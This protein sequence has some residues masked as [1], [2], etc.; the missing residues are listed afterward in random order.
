MA[1]GVLSKTVM[2]TSQLE[3]EGS[4]ARSMDDLAK[5]VLEGSS[6]DT[7]VTL[8]FEEQPVIRKPLIQEISSTAQETSPRFRLTKFVDDFSGSGNPP[9]FKIDIIGVDENNALERSLELS[10]DRSVVRY[11]DLSIP[12]GTKA[13]EI[14]AFYT[15]DTER[16][17]I[18]IY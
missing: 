4:V 15:R 17:Q 13:T 11:G 5:N 16:L 7:A 3:N 18:F 2:K 12:I 9:S 14:E 10:A 6:E 1:K 8:P